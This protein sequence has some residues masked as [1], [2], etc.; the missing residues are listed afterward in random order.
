MSDICPF[1]DDEQ[2]QPQQPQQQQQEQQQQN[3]KSKE[4]HLHI[5]MREHE[6]IKQLGERQLHHSTTALPIGDIWIG[7][8]DKPALVIERKTAADFSSSITD[9]RYREQRGRLLAFSQET[10]ARISYLIEG[11]L[12]CRLGETAVLKLIARMQLVHGIPVFRTKNVADTAYFTQCMLE[13]WQQEPTCFSAATTAQRAVDAIHVVKK[14]N[15]N[16]PHMFAVSVLCQSPG[17]SVK[18]A[19]AWLSELGSLQAVLTAPEAQLAAVKVGGRKQAAT[20]KK[21]RSLWA[22][23]G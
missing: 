17:V 15:A 5:D 11:P 12:T 18:V 20:A 8:Y 1:M 2:V 23:F 13:Y 21:F 10:G 14:D 7:P 22:A 4:G 9:G 16:D 19:E 6:L 3:Q